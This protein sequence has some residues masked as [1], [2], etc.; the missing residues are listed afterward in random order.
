MFLSILETLICSFIFSE[1]VGWVVH[2]LLHSEKIEWLSRSHMIHHL[3][4]YGPKTP[5][6]RK[7]E[8]ISSTDNRI[9]IGNIGLEWLL[10]LGFVVA[11]EVGANILLGTSTAMILLFT[12]SSI[13]Y[14]IFLF[15][16]MH[17]NMH[18]KNFWMEKTPIIKNWFLNSRR[19][20]DIHHLHFSETGLNDVNYGICF[21]FFDKLLGSYKKDFSKFNN[22][23]YQAAINRYGYLDKS[24]SPESVTPTS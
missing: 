2:Q 24:G 13:A 11:I 4:V 23:G 19:L 5:Q 10:P 1:F 6:R 20:H 8:Y 22:E 17:N 16:Y 21:H 3:R 9:S 14:G 7:E 15:G 18:R 12:G